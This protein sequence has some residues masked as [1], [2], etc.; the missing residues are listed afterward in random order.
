M[1]N[2]PDAS[3]PTVM[4]NGRTKKYQS[5]SFW[6]AALTKKSASIEMG[7]FVFITQQEKRITLFL[8]I[9]FTLNSNKPLL[10]VYQGF[11]N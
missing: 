10:I 2:L 1:K 3:K 4:K 11:R 5:L 9:S 7:V 6:V 8:A